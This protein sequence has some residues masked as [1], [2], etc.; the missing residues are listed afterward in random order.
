MLKPGTPA[1]DFTL[2][3]QDGNPVSLHATLKQGPVLLYFYPADFT[4]GCTREACMIRDQH[5]EIMDVGVTVLGISSQSE[6]S[7]TRF[8]KKHDLPFTLLADT[9]KEVVKLY[10]SRGFLGITKRITYMIDADGIITDAVDAMFNID[11]HENLINKALQ[12]FV[13]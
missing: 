3:D 13:Q 11:A 4:P 8:Q 1:P 2:P 6:D 9:S 12:S 5:E 7:H 10:E